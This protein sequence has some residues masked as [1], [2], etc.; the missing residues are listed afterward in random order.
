MNELAK[1]CGI[2]YDFQRYN[3]WHHVRR[4]R[5]DYGLQTPEFDCQCMLL[6][7]EAF[8]NAH[9]DSKGMEQISNPENLCAVLMARKVKDRL[10]WH[11]GIYLDGV[12]SH[13]DRCARQVRIEPLKALEK[14]YERV[15]FWR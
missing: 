8:E 2:A 12:V 15:E 3:C 11:S 10:V 7:N 9:Y 5:S 1:Y 14:V 4:V 6:E 13:C